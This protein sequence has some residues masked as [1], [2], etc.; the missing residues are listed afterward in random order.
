[1]ER[2]VTQQGTIEVLGVFRA[3][4]RLMLKVKLGAC[5]DVQTGDKLESGDLSYVVKAVSFSPA[6]AWKNGIRLVEVDGGP[7]PRIGQ[8]VQ[9]FRCPP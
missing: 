6:D 1:M 5:S 8:R 4:G 2:D 9:V 7:E 3:A